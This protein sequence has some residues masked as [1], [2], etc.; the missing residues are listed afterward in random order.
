[1]E[2][3]ID[4]IITEQVI[5]HEQLTIIAKFSLTHALKCQKGALRDKTQPAKIT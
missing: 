1:M 2:N 4:I 5:K 3:I